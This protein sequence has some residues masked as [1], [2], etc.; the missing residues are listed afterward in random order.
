MPHVI[1]DYSANMESRIDMAAFCDVLRITAI[2]TGVLV[3]PGVRVRAVRADFASIADGNP[4]HGYVDISV[5]LREG[6][7]LEVRKAATAL[8]FEAAKEFL[9]PAMEKNSIALSFEMRN[10]DAE[11]SPKCGTIRDHLDGKKDV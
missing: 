8:I 4:D 11:L 3:L 7:D 2:E 6:R 1:V 10:I 9:A 5:R